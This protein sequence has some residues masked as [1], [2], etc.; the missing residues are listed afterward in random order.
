MPAS[1][2]GETGHERGGGQARSGISRWSHHRHTASKHLAIGMSLA[3]DGRERAWAAHGL[4]CPEPC[5]RYLK[6]VSCSTPTGPRAWNRP[7]AM[8]IS[9]PNPNSPPSANCVE[10]LCSTIAESTSRRNLVACP[11]SS[12]TMGSVTLDMRDGR[13]QPIDHPGGYYGIEIFGRP[14]FLGRRPDTRIDCA[15]S[16]VAA[17]LAA[18]VEQRG[19]ERSKMRGRRRGIDKKRL[20][21]AADAR[22]PHFGIEDDRLCHIETCRPIHIDVTDA[23]EMGKDR[24]ARLLLHARNQA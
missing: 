4:I 17:H 12:V 6:V 16:F 11:A 1:C 15:G 24:Y 13:I 9:A 3:C 19:D 10:A 5:T 22:T 8:P 20:G 7:V 2:A 14:V 23:L 21:S 18:C